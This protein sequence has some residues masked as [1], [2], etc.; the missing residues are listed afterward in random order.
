MAGI[1]LSFFSFLWAIL[2]ICVIIS[3][4]WIYYAIKKS[5]TSVLIFDIIFQLMLV[6][7]C[8]RVLVNPVNSDEQSYYFITLVTFLMNTTLTSFI[9]LE[10]RDTPRKMSL[11]I[12]WLKIALSVSGVYTAIPLGLYFVKLYYLPHN[13]EERDEQVIV[14]SPLSEIGEPIPAELAARYGDWEFLGQGGFARVFRATRQDGKMIAVKIPREFTMV[15]GMNFVAEIQNWT[16][17]SHENIVRVYAFNVLPIPFFELE[18]CDTSLETTKTPIDPLIASL[19]MH[20]ICR[21][22]AYAHDHGIVHRDLKPSNILIQGG[23]CKISDWGLCKELCNEPKSSQ[24]ACTI[25]YAA[26]E[27][28]HGTGTDKRTDIWQVG[29]IFY[30]LVTGILPFPGEDPICQIAGITTRQPIPPSDIVLAAAGVEQIILRCLEKNPDDRWQD[31]GE[32]LKVM[33]SFLREELAHRI[34]RAITEK[35]NQVAA[36]YACQL[37]ILSLEEED[38]H[39]GYRAAGELVN[40]LPWHRQG[41]VRELMK[42]MQNAMQDTTAG[43]RSHM[44]EIIKQAREVGNDLSDRRE[45][46]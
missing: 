3:G 5:F 2:I 43:L 46:E 21:G 27:Q 11:S 23:L 4:I 14:S 35:N 9:L 41:P 10:W 7:L 25:P 36:W 6:V 22:L 38:L 15:T 29:A 32:L 17:L 26:P 45:N 16:G 42:K 40:F 20:G 28:I 19:R 33:T 24:F 30:E 44:V 1:S 8:L 39:S 18:L 12:W 37:L 34:D 31:S 13:K